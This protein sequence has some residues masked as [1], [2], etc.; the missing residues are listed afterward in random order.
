[1]IIEPI[2]YFHSPFGGRFGIPRQSG[3]VE[4]LRGE[5]RFAEQFRRREALKGLDGFDYL[6]L[7]WEF[8]A[9]KTK[10]HSSTVR[11]P[12]LG[13]NTTMGVW[14]TRSPFRP[15]PIGLSCVRIDRIDFETISIH[16]LGADL[17]DGTPVYDIKPYLSYC[18]AH[19]GA[20]CGFVDSNQWQALDVT[21][22]DT[23]KKRLLNE[24]G[25]EGLETLIQVLRQD[26]RPQYQS[27]PDKIYGMM[28]QGQ[29]IHFTVDGNLLTVI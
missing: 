8:S 25:A 22:S 3:L 4:G 29:D 7:I 28:Y 21:I 6:W 1:M 5:I 16:V 15:N 18:D 17:C 27:D 10:A 24:L 26:P 20:A 23:L 2:A 13:G 9:N 14:A 12:R 19:P 11:P